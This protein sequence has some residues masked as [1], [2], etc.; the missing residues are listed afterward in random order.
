M[1]NCVYTRMI[2]SNL[3]YV[4]SLKRESDS[5]VIDRIKLSM[6]IGQRSHLFVVYCIFCLPLP[7]RS[8][9][10]TTYIF[11]LDKMAARAT[12]AF[13]HFTL[14]LHL[15]LL[16]NYNYG[17]RFGDRSRTLHITDNDGPRLRKNP[18]IIDK[19]DIKNFD[20][21]VNRDR[22]DVSTNKSNVT[23]KV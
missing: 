19:D 4:L 10:K 16:I 2:R 21:P 5:H 9:I 7:Y 6:P 15:F 23:T 8:S 14:I 11:S 20:I 12:S 13:Y 18:L 1:I 22:R 17:Q 3:L